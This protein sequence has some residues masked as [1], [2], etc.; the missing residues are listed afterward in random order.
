[1]VAWGENEIRRRPDAADFLVFV[2]ASAVGH[3]LA[4]IIGQSRQH[5]VETRLKQTAL[6]LN[7]LHAGLDVGDLVD[8]CR[9]AL[10]ITLQQ[11]NLLRGLVPALLQ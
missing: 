3:I 1:M 5:L 2:F 4:E 7:I 9:S 8:Q 11:A 6:L 10:A